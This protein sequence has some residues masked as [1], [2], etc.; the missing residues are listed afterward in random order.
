MRHGHFAAHLRRT[1]LQY[2]SQRD[3]LVAE[4]TRRS[5]DH[6]MVDVPDQGMHLIAYLRHRRSDTAIEAAARRH[7]IA[8]RAI[9]PMYKKA[10]P[11]SGLML[12]FS[13]LSC[14]AIVTAARRVAQVL[15]E[16]AHASGPRTL[17]GGEEVVVSRVGDARR[18][19]RDGSRAT[20]GSGYAAHGVYPLDARHPAEQ[21]VRADGLGG[22][23]QPGDSIWRWRV[24]TF[25]HRAQ[26]LAAIERLP[27]RPCVMPADRGS[28][29]VEEIGLWSHERPFV[30]SDLL[31][32]LSAFVDLHALCPDDH[33]QRLGRAR[34]E[35]IRHVN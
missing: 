14:E 7:G 22:E 28:A 17:L 19:S 25:L 5:Q 11:R 20:A 2:R 12:G 21:A 3:T 32:L 16:E 9:H 33:R 24:D 27:M 18:R 1:R 26:D 10:R 23:Q 15:E 31:L 29:R 8:V 30:A 4:L 13:G 6:V 34:L 35:L